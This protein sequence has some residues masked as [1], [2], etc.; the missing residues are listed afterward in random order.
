[1]SVFLRIDR[2]EKLSFKLKIVKKFAYYVENCTKF[3]FDICQYQNSQPVSWP[4]FSVI[5]RV[6]SKLL[7]KNKPPDCFC[8]T[9]CGRMVRCRIS[10]NK[11]ILVSKL[12]ISPLATISIGNVQYR[13][14][15]YHYS[16][17]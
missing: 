17:S 2:S 13:F 7:V 5:V 9:F 6:F 11:I 4:N 3:G 1:M 8:E 16:F 12:I 15:K 10:C 14:S